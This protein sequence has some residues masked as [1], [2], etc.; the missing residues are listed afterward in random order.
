MQLN[1][2][3]ELSLHLFYIFILKFIYLKGFLPE[4][5][6]NRRMLS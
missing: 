4:F 5:S 3:L 2:F 1:W 6:C